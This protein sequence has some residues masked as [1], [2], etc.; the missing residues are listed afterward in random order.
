MTQ[1]LNNKVALV[2]GGSRGIGA[3]IVQQLAEEGAVVYF[4]YVNSVREA[5]QLEADL[6]AKGCRVKAIRADSSVSGEVS[7]AIDDLIQKHQRFDI[8]VN[9]AGVFIGKPFHEHTMEEFDEIFAI[10]VRAVTEACLAAAK[11]MNLRGR[12]ITIGSGMA[13]K[14]PFAGATFYTMSKSALQGLTK[15]LARELGPKEITVNLVQP[16]SVNTDMN[17]EDSPSADF[18]RSLMAIPKY[19]K[20]RHIAAMASY[21]VSEDAEYTTGAVF[22]V[23]G[24]ANS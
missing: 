21:L 8:L 3:A 7:R 10:N 15:S 24:G 2:T 16:G 23:D 6:S 14:V 12:I 20:A 18:Q 13:D 9:S 1:H 17:P 22:T 11:N 4:T 5:E 19:G